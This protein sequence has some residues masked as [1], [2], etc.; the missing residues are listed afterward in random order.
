MTVPR[1]V[2]VLLLAA[3]LSGCGV[4]TMRSFFTDLMGCE[5]PLPDVDEDSDRG[6]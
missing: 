3:A 2:A 4:R 1:L 6:R 5:Q